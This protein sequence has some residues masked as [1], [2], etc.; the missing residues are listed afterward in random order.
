M[1]SNRQ[2]SLSQPAL[3]LGTVGG[4][5]VIRDK[6]TGDAITV[7][8]R[9]AEG[10]AGARHTR[11]LIISTDRGFIRLWHYPANWHDMSDAELIALADRPVQSRSA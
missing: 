11:C 3:N 2:D 6:N 8:E 4:P 10:V 1:I 5:R 7:V 9:Q